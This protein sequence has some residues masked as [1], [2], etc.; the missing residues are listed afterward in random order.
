MVRAVA[1]EM[2]RLD[3]GAIEIRKRNRLEPW[4]ETVSRLEREAQTTT[5]SRSL[6]RI[7]LRLD[8]TYPNLHSNVDISPLIRDQASP[9]KR[10]EILFASD[11]TSWD[12][13][14]YR[15]HKVNSWSGPEENRPASGDEV[16]AI[17]FIPIEKWKEEALHF[18]KF[19]LRN[20]CEADLPSQFQQGLL[21]WN[22]TSPLNYSL[23][24]G[25]RTWTIEVPL[26][27]PP[28]NKKPELDPNHCE[29]FLDRYPGFKMAWAGERACVYENELKDIAILRITSFQYSKVSPQAPIRSTRQEVQAL[30][31]WWEAKNKSWR[32]LVVDVIDNTGGQDPIAYYQLV[33]AKPFQEQYVR[34]RKGTELL[35]QHLRMSPTGIF[36][37]S[38]GHENWLQRLMS[39]SAWSSIPEGDFLPPVPQFCA[40]EENCETALWRPRGEGFRGKVSVLMNQWCISSCDG[41][42]WQ[43]KDKANAKLFGQPQAADSGYSRL[44]IHISTDENGR[45]KSTLTPIRDPKPENTLFSQTVVVSQSTDQYGNN[46]DGLPMPLD[47]FVPS[48][49][50]QVDWH[51]SVLERALAHY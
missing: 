11:W 45:I 41:F 38:A 33:L 37:S 19:P 9:M 46:I 21:F 42:V 10:P 14:S 32:H 20:Q 4:S 5:D 6:S 8:Q 29:S 7:L 23:R 35:N 2:E 27:Q 43:M 22:G 26:A 17:N 16:T 25:N 39:S 50:D 18:C 30:R 31:P 34:F 51:T 1:T 49:W 36:W 44:T 15:V 47:E 28:E 3:G 12:E 24:R 40:S 48:R 13:V